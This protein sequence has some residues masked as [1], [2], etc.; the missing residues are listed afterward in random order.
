MN[1]TEA[2][3]WGVARIDDPNRPVD[4]PVVVVSPN[5][6]Q[7]GLADLDDEPWHRINDLIRDRTAT[8]RSAVWTNSPAVVD[9]LFGDCPADFRDWLLLSKDGVEFRQMTEP[10]AEAFWTAYQVGIMQVSEI[11]E[12]KG[13]L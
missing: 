9:R 10:E 5:V 13:L 11:L 3:A 4:R 8:R 2:V 1:F 12:S 6:R 7:T